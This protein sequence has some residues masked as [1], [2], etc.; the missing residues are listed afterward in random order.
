MSHAVFINHFSSSVVHCLLD[1]H[2]LY[3]FQWASCWIL[4]FLDIAPSSTRSQPKISCSCAA[5]DLSSLVFWSLFW[6]HLVSPL[7]ILLRRVGSVFDFCIQLSRLCKAFVHC[8][9]APGAW[10]CVRW[11]LDSA[12]LWHH[13]H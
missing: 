4:H 11:S 6:F 13:R 5:F 2:D 3:I 7:I 9:M 12:G 10:H 1:F 8:S